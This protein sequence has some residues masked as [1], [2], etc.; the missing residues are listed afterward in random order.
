MSKSKNGPTQISTI[1]TNRITRSFIDALYA[2][3]DGMVLLTSEESPILQQLD[4]TSSTYGAT[5]VGD[6]AKDPLTFNPME[7]RLHE[8]LDLRDGVRLYA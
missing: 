1:F 5:A 3:L 4:A 8:L 6:L 7:M 2:F